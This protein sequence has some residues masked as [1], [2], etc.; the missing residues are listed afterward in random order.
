MG[1]REQK[2][3]ARRLEGQ[4]QPEELGERG[5]WVPPRGRSVLPGECVPAQALTARENHLAA[6]SSSQLGEHAAPFGSGFVLALRDL[7]LP[8]QFQQARALELAFTGHVEPPL[9][10]RRRQCGIAS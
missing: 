5:T 4:V 7:R 8:Q 2:A 9:D 1:T 6:A 10:G 3:G